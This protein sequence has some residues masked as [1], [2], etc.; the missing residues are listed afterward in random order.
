MTKAT[1]AISAA[2]L[3]ANSGLITFN[4]N[5]EDLK[6]IFTGAQLA[7]I[8]LND[9]IDDLRLAAGRTAIDIEGLGDALAGVNTETFVATIGLVFESLATRIQGVVDAIGAER[10][11]LREAALQIINPTVMSR[12]AIKRGIAGVNTV[13]PGNGGIASAQ[14]RL[15]AADAL[16]AQRLSAQAGALAGYTGAKSAADSARAQAAAAVTASESR[17]KDLYNQHYNISGTY[18]LDKLLS[19]AVT[20]QNVSVRSVHTGNEVPTTETLRKALVALES[21]RAAEAAQV[22]SAAAGQAGLNSLLTA[23][24][25]AVGA[26]TSAQNAAATAVQN[27]KNAQLAYVSAI[28]NFSIDASKSVGKLGK[29]R[30]ETVKYY[31]AQK[32]LADLMATSAGGLRGAVA[33]YRYSQLTD[34]Q[35]LNKLQSDYA[36]T[37]AL[38]LST[39]GEALAGYGDK[40][41]GQLGPL[42]EKAKEV[43]SDST[44]SAFEKTTL[45]RAE[46]I[47]GRLEALTP[48]NYAADSLVMLG[49]IDATLAALDASSKSAEKIISD[50]IKAGSDRTADGLRA[51]I[52]ALTGKPVQAFATGGA[53]TNGVVSRP[54]AFNTAVMGEAGSEAIMP[55][56]NI[57]GSL[58]VRTTGGTNTARLEAL[59][60]RQTQELSNMRAELRAI[61]TTNAKMARLADRNDSEG[62]LVRTDADTP[63]AT[64]AA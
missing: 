61:A 20:S 6:P 58:G 47:A 35:Q 29:L 22:A 42:L 62:M 36:K 33:D 1:G 5:A 11:S 25:N 23:Y 10:V 55:L 43:M 15:S 28:Q 19:G 63:L 8:L 41:S 45:A 51:V 30:E 14:Q 9:E 53:F 56:T 26:T 48:K 40:L 13:L 31:E 7:G 12:A 59:V 49:Q 24:N 16:V 34:S 3:D 52:A 18:G 46:A 27:A 50:A 64:V 54:T 17:I 60:E 2:F 21:A 38:G 32:Q 57:N 39:N 4:S 37:Y 44:Y